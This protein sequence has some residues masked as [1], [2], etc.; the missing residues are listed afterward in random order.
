M[1]NRNTVAKYGI[2]AGLMTL[3]G[4]AAAALPTEIGTAIQ[5]AQADGQE[6]GYL[7]LG[8]A[9]VVGVIFWLKRRAG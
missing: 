1:E 4:S 5:T 2:G 7:L 3:A 9:V 8:M 6:L